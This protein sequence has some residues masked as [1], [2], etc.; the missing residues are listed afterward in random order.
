MGS[1]LWRG[2]RAATVLESAPVPP[3][4]N[5]PVSEVRAMLCRG[6]YRGHDVSVAMGGDAGANTPC[7][8][9]CSPACTAMHRIAL[10]VVPEQRRYPSRIAATLWLKA[11]F[12]RFQSGAVYPMQSTVI[13]GPA[14][15]PSLWVACWPIDRAGRDQ[16]TIRATKAGVPSCRRGMLLQDATRRIVFRGPRF[17]QRVIVEWRILEHRCR[18]L[19]HQTIP[20]VAGRMGIV[21][22]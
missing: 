15:T 11:S 17:P 19:G 14:P 5:R 6:S 21:V 2:G 22:F 12:I 13:L 18:A 1:T 8:V 9:P 7:W 16:T 20:P 4:G 3:A 10:L